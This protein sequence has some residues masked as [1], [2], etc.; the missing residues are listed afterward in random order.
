M[1]TTVKSEVREDDA[2]IR[3]MARRITEQN[4]QKMNPAVPGVVGSGGPMQM[5]RPG[6]PMIQNYLSYQ[7]QAQGQGRHGQQ[8]QSLGQIPAVDDRL[9][10]S[11][12]KGRFG[13]CEFEKNFIPFIFRSANV[14]KYTSVRMVERK[15]LGRFLSV[16]PPEVNSCHC[17][18]SY[19]ITDAES[20]LLNDINLRHTDCYFGKEAFTTKDLVVRLKDAKEFYRFLDLVSTNNI[21]PFPRFTHSFIGR[22]TVSAILIVRSN[23]M[24]QCYKKLVMKKSNASDRCGFFRINGESVVP[25]TVREGVKYVPLFYFEGET[26]HL[27]LKSEV[28]DG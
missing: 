22:F 17:I 5:A 20:K 21:L 15:L 27:K 9:D 6:Q 23:V 26:E 10:V 2:E 19:Y 1:G 16:L 13:W 12:K 24:F 7:Q 18:R 8:P 11:S 14:E 28:V 25:Y 3:E 4:R